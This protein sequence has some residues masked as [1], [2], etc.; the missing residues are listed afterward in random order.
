MSGDET[1][2]HFSFLFHVASQL[3][4]VSAIRKWS[5]DN[6]PDWI[7]KA[8]LSQSSR[9]ATSNNVSRAAQGQHTSDAFIATRARKYQ[10]ARCLSM[11]AGVA[12]QPKQDTVSM[13]P[14]ALPPVEARRALLLDTKMTFKE[15][16][17]KAQALGFTLQHGKYSAR[18]F[19]KIGDTI[20]AIC[21]RHG[22][23][24]PECVRI[25]RDGIRGRPQ[26]REILMEWRA[27]V[28]DALDRLV[29]LVAKRVRSLDEARTSV[30][31]FTSEESAN[32]RHLVEERGMSNWGQI[33]QLMGRTYSTVRTH[34]ERV[35]C[36]PPTRVSGKWYSD[37]I[38]RLW[39]AY[40]GHSKPGQSTPWSV[41]AE[42]VGTRSRFQ[43]LVYACVADRTANVAS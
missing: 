12:A 32:L 35:I 14:A 23:T 2:P 40:D 15:A 19:E 28:A 34:W 30:G 22:I 6:G 24:K 7:S 41:I 13:A 26:D 21:R 20:A 36:R 11:M 39:A 43:C 31:A 16:L 27:M 10:R 8:N 18:E 29:Y 3:S 33:G 38:E 42:E 25:I 4:T 17:P 5:N 9:P 1:N 37:E